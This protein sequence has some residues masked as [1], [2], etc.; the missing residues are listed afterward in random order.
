MDNIHY[1]SNEMIKALKEVFKN[2]VKINKINIIDN[3][4][5]SVKFIIYDYLYLRL[6]YKNQKYITYIENF[7]DDTIIN[8]SFNFNYLNNYIVYI[9]YW[10]NI[11]NIAML[12]IPT[13]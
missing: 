9:N 10:K 6:D 8:P 11:K 12:K 1:I 13:T 2:D 3:N 5:F 4:S 7:N